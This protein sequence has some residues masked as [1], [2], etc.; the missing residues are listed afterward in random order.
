MREEDNAH[1]DVGNPGVD[2]RVQYH[3]VGVCGLIIPWN[4]PLLMAAWKVAPC[5]AAGCTGTC[6]RRF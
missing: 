4:Y 6:L 2:S 1:V 3:P 5:L